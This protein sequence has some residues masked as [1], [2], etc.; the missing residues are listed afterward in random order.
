[1]KRRHFLKNA[2]T[3][4]S[5]SFMPSSL[6]AFSENKRLRTA[7]IGIGG[8][9]AEDLKAISSHEMVDVVALCDVDSNAIAAAKK[10]HPNAKVFA[11][12][13]VMLKEMNKDIDA[14]IVSTPDHTHAPASMMAMD[15]ANRYIAKNH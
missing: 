3:L 11:D 2:A 14:V 13:R 10:L 6:W 12:Y 9:G 8:M 1:M 5:V 15:M 7:H 4:A